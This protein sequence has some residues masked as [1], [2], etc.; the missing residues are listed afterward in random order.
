MSE[1]MDILRANKKSLKLMF[2]SP[3]RGTASRAREFLAVLSMRSKKDA[4]EKVLD[5]EPLRSDDHPGGLPTLYG[6][7]LAEVEAASKLYK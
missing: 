2:M 7:G 5:P 6:A 1:L 3:L 4:R